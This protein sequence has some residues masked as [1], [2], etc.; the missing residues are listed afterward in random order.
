MTVP[1][2]VADGGSLAVLV[3][4]AEWSAMNRQITS[5]LPYRAIPVRRDAFLGQR[6]RMV[7]DVD[8]DG[9]SDIALG[10]YS[11]DRGAL[12]TGSVALL[13]VPEE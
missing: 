1:D 6:V 7:G 9:R 5:E 4:G 10:S 3:P 8:G 11:G 2:Y 12:N 13:P